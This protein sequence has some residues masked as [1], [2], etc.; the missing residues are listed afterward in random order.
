MNPRILSI[1]PAVVAE[2]AAVLSA[3]GALASQVGRPGSRTN[4]EIFFLFTKPLSVCYNLYIYIDKGLIQ[5]CV[6]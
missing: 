2:T 4:T 3:A 1:N 6:T 5:K